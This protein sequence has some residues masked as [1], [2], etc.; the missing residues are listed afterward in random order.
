MEQ[1]KEM[2]YR[3][4]K[5]SERQHLELVQMISRCTKLHSIT[6]LGESQFTRL[7]AMLW[8]EI[9]KDYDKEIPNH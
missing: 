1:S 4:R 5:A 2:E 6:R 3:S 7:Y 8:S 9:H